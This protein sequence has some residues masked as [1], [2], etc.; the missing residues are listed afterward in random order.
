MSKK[1]PFQWDVER[2]MGFVYPEEDARKCVEVKRAKKDGKDYIVLTEWRF[3]KKK[4]EDDSIVED[5]NPIKG[6]SIPA[7]N[8]DE[9]NDLVQE[10]FANDPAADPNEEDDEA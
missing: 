10:D 3:F 5:W 9:L 2:S 4:T 6:L 1:E 8:W 7:H